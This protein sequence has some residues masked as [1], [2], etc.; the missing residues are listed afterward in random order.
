MKRIFELMLI[1][2]VIVTFSTVSFGAVFVSVSIAPPL[3][4]VY[5]QPVCPGWG[6]FGCQAIGRTANL[7]TTGFLVRGFW[8]VRRCAMDAG[9]LGLG[10]TGF[11]CGMKV[12]GD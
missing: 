12:F 10:Q 3:L 1:A 8:P 6:T 2:V 4:P 7:A 9:L 11:I 5:T